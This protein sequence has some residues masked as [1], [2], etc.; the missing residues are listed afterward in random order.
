MRL[1]VG[2]TV[3]HGS[4][5]VK[6]KNSWHEDKAKY[7]TTFSLMCFTNGKVSFSLPQYFV[8]TLLFT[9]LTIICVSLLNQINTQKNVNGILKTSLLYEERKW[10]RNIKWTCKCTYNPRKLF[11]YCILISFKN[12]SS[13]TNVFR[14]PRLK[15]LC[16]WIPEKK[17]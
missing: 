10:S 7:K 12:I 4:N 5:K 9:V 17:I 8:V 11:K 14:E 13:K 2:L 1:A 15:A 3:F 6:H 16:V